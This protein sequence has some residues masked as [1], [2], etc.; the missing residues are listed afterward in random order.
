[1]NGRRLNTLAVVVLLAAVLLGLGLRLD[2]VHANPNVQHDE[3][4]SYATASG[5]LGA[6][7][8]AIQGGLSGRWVP[9]S[10]WQYY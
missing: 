6:F 3:A 2:A 4:W 7:E 8:Q 1:V 10:A 9:A 5:R